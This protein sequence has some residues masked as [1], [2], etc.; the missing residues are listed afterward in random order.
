MRH[1][2]L[3]RT[4]AGAKTASRGLPHRSVSQKNSGGYW[5]PFSESVI[6]DAMF[7]VSTGAAAIAAASNREPLVKKNPTTPTMRAGAGGW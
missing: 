2:I 3:F 4:K 7:V 1:A 6:Y 5:D